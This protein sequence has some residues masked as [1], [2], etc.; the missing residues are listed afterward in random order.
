MLKYQRRRQYS[1]FKNLIFGEEKKGVVSQVEEKIPAVAS[2][3][4]TVP[5]D[6]FKVRDPSGSRWKPV[7]K[8]PLFTFEDVEEVEE[9]DLNPNIF[10][11]PVRP[12]ILHRNIVWYQAMKRQGS[13][14]VKD[15]SDVSGGGKKPW[16][17]KGTGRARAG[18]IRSPIWRKGGKAHGPKGKDWSYPLNKKVQELGFKSLLSLRYAQK[19]L[20]IT[21]GLYGPD[22]ELGE[23]PIEK[24]KTF[25]RFYDACGFGTLVYVYDGEEDDVELLSRVTGNIH[26]FRLKD[27]YDL[28]IYDLFKAKSLMISTNALDRIHDSF[29]QTNTNYYD[30]ASPP[31][32]E[33]KETSL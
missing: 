2:T 33:N 7:L 30:V 4:A 10:L 13:V 25:R 6:K 32:L 3:G 31:S 20:Y 26:S 18:S 8:A 1:F 11:V 23:L 12:D 14:Y 29:V 24:T 21:K 15:R 27:V 19:A 16:R 22:I 28:N 9:V 5:M 17:Q